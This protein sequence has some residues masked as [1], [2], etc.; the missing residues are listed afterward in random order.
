MLTVSCWA[1]AAGLLAIV[2]TGPAT[3]A[4]GPASPADSASPADPAKARD[5]LRTLLWPQPDAPARTDHRGRSLAAPDLR[6]RIVVVAF[7][8]ADCSIACV[9]RTLA[10][11]KVARALPD[12]LR[13]RVVMVGID[14]DPVGG[15]GRLRA[16]AD[17]LVGTDTPLRLLRSDAAG[18]AALAASLR[19]P[20]Q[21]LPE[22]PPVVL[23]FDRRG[24]IAMTYGSDPLDGPRL[25]D[26]IAQ[27]ETFADGLDRPTGASAGPSPTL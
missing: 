4:S 23:L 19:Y 26:D 27:L 9:V 24:Q 20:A 15:R 17:G 14:T 6:D 25:L 5:D 16:F 11:D 7:V 12:A 3:T 10:L 21:A 2:L 13:D 8:G 22:P 1:A 18:T